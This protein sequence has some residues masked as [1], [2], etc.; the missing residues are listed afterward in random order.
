MVAYSCLGADEC[1]LPL[2]LISHNSNIFRLF[3]FGLFLSELNE[4]L[5]SHT[6]PTSQVTTGYDKNWHKPVASPVSILSSD[7]RHI[8]G[9]ISRSRLWVGLYIYAIFSPSIPS[10]EIHEAHVRPYLELHT[11]WNPNC[12]PCQQLHTKQKSR[13]VQKW[14]DDSCSAGSHL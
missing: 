6:E 2:C 1:P 12:V 11:L 3:R 14:N 9:K 10:V 4:F 7:R 8:T 13:R 5:R